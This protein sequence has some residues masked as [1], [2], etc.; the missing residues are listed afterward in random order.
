MFW[1]LWEC[2][3]SPCK[4][5]W[6]HY[7]GSTPSGLE[8]SR[9]KSCGSFNFCR[10]VAVKVLLVLLY[11][12]LQKDCSFTQASLTKTMRAPMYDVGHRNLSKRLLCETIY[13]GCCVLL[14]SA[15]MYFPQVFTARQTDTAKLP[16][17]RACTPDFD[18]ALS[19]SSALSLLWALLLY[20]SSCCLRTMFC[21]GTI[22]ALFWWYVHNK[23][24]S[25]PAHALS[26]MLESTCC[27][28]V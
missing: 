10:H 15:V 11:I 3:C 9:V 12:V 13:S 5:F 25:K 17:L 23:D 19:Q 18:S 26:P 28:H 7:A 6:S 1:R 16:F 8:L 22:D 2:L 4:E 27:A 21:V 24:S 14:A 20:L